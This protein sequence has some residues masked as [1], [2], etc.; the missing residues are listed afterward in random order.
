MRRG[1]RGLE[2]T[3]DSRPLAQ[4]DKGAVIE[5]EEFFEA[6]AVVEMMVGN[7]GHPDIRDV[8]PEDL[9]IVRERGR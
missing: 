5:F 4:K 9:R 7:D 6:S 3:V 1:Y 8:D 2:E